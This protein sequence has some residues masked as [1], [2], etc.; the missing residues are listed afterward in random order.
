MSVYEKMIIFGEDNLP[1]SLGG[2]RADFFLPILR[3]EE[4]KYD[5][6][7]TSFSYLGDINQS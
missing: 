3:S 2:L 7:H 6:H 1:C 4:P 5:T